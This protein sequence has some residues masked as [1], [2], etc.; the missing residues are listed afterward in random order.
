MQSGLGKRIPL[1][2]TRDE[3][4]QLAGNLNS[5]LER[6]EALIAEVKQVSDNVAHDLRTPL[7]RMPGRLGKADARQRNSA[8]DQALIDDTMA[9]LDAVLRMFPPHSGQWARPKPCRCSCPSP[10]GQY[11]DDGQRAGPQTPTSVS[12]ARAGVTP[13]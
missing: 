10:W 12:A 8:H 3:W 6:I 7:T 11:R 4:D 13:P 1:R 5:M 2:G 9:E